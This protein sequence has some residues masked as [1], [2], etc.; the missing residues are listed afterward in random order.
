ML[1]SYE[2]LTSYAKSKGGHI[3]TEPELRLFFDKY[4]GGFDAGAN[5]GFRNWHTVP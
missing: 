1:A 5:V 3:P 2:Q 4:E